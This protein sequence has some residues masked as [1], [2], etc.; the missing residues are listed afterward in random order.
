MKHADLESFRE[1]IENGIPFN[2]YLGIKL[3]HLEYKQCKLL[4]PFQEGFVGDSRRNA[5]HGGIISTLADTSGGFAVWSTGCLQDRI[6]T[7]DLRVD[8]LQPAVMKDVIA[9]SKVKLLGNRVAN[10]YTAILDNSDPTLLLAEARSVY[11]IRRAV[12]K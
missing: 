1:L 6:S 12:D 4:L 7:I 5:L 2:N 10:V 3:M 11:N 9:D 8:Y